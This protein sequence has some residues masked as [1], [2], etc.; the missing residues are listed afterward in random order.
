MSVRLSHT[1]SGEGDI[2]IGHII[3]ATMG[4]K[5][6]YPDLHGAAAEAEMAVL[7]RFL[8][9]GNLMELLECASDIGPIVRYGKYRT[10]ES[11]LGDAGEHDRAPQ[12]DYAVWKATRAAVA[13]Y[14]EGWLPGKAS[15]KK[16]AAEWML[17]PERLESASE[18]YPGGHLRHL[19]PRLPRP[20]RQVNHA[21]LQRELPPAQM[22]RRQEE[23]EGARRL[24]AIAS[25]PPRRR[26][27]ARRAARRPPDS[28]RRSQ[29]AA[30]DDR[31][32]IAP[33]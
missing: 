23:R 19:R 16:I 13:R 24:A 30:R 12:S 27:P 10:V 8:V 4:R 26:S 29:S 20:R 9:A 2:V 25:T 5:G 17:T 32:P 6:L 15:C 14:G 33:L 3:P 11:L 22:V 28:T 31:C 21:F 1:H 18:M 7:A